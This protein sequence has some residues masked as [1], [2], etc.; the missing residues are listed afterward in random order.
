MAFFTSSGKSG[1]VSPRDIHAVDLMDV[2]HGCEQRRAAGCARSRCCMVAKMRVE[3]ALC[4][5]ITGECR[6]C[7]PCVL[8]NREARGKTVAMLTTLQNRVEVDVRVWKRCRGSD[9]GRGSGR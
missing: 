4:Y 1:T 8:S 5:T 3:E 2:F 9:S 6:C 7:S